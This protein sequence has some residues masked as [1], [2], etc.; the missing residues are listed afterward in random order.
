[1]SVF[2][3][4]EVIVAGGGVAGGTA[5]CLLAQAGVKVALLEREPLPRHKICGEFI[6]IEAQEYLAQVG[7]DLAGLGA[8]AVSGL[9]LVSDGRCIESPLP[10]AGMGLSR[11][12]LDSAL[13]ERAQA[14][15]AQICRGRRIIRIAHD[16]HFE[17]E[18][19][20]IGTVAARTLFLATGKHDLRGWARQPA[21]APE[22]LIGFKMHFKLRPKQRRAL[23]QHVEL[24]LFS[25]GYAGLQM[26]EQG[27][28]NLCL[29]VQRGYL[30]R[31][32]GD[33]TGLLA[34]LQNECPHLR[35]RLEG[36]Q[37]MM[38]KPLAIFRVP[39]G[40]LHRDSALE[41]G[42]LYRLGDQ[43]AVTPSF[44]GDGMAIALHSA[45]LAVKAYLGYRS[46]A[47]YHR[48]MRREVLPQMR[49]ANALY[50]IGRSDTGRR[51][52]LSALR[53]W[54]RSMEIAASL[55]RLRIAQ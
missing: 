43:F 15:G 16:R 35:E 50:R 41:S 13:L 8:H 34:A 6:S 9:R 54:P 29:L 4:V 55:T 10:F 49:A 30:T 47:D 38:D 24:L 2:D 32:G 21:R 25:A 23:A 22:E 18:V 28:V 20:G 7:L 45:A 1:M 5:A 26:V 40:Y 44:S 17:L 53:M 36:A 51:A 19:C 27:R 42:E 3:A 52:L 48:R 33:W 31:A 11:R 39:Y 12:T 37:T 46:A 14:C